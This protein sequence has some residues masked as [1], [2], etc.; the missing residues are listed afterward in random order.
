M[1]K[2]F[3][4]NEN[5]FDH[6]TEKNNPEPTIAQKAISPLKTIP[7]N[8]NTAFIEEKT[9]RDLAGLLKVIAKAKNKS[10]LTRGRV[11]FVQMARH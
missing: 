4:A 6:P 11:L 1:P 3:I 2:S 8:N 9:A 5:M 7:I 10:S